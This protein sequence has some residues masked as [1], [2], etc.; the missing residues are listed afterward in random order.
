[1]TWWWDNWVRPYNLYGHFK[2][3]ADYL[4][5]IDWVKEKSVIMTALIEPAPAN[6]GPFQFS[7]RIDW[8]ETLHVRNLLLKTAPWKIW[9]KCTAFIHGRYH[10]DMAP[11]PMFLLD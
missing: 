4:E 8:G 6:L 1:M 2:R 11:N 7:P 5:G 9:M 10:R 3:L